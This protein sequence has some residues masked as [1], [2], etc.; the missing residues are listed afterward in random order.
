MNQESR[1]CQNCKA[2]FTIEPEDF[3]FYQKMSVPAPTWCPECRLQRRLAFFNERILYKRNCDLCSKSMMTM[4]APA[5]PMP[6]YCNECWWSDNWDPSSYWLDYDPLRPFFAQW[7]DLVRKTPHVALTVNYPMLINSDYV[8]HTGPAKNCY[9]I[10]TADYC[11]N[12]LYSS[13]LAHAKDSMDC[14]DLGTSELCYESTLCLKCSRVFFSDYCHDCHDIYFSKNLSGCSDCF[15]C[16]NLRNKQYYIFN[17]P[18]SKEAY[19]KSLKSFGLT[20]TRALK[21]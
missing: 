3:A 2:S 8:N 20:R 7:H 21:R 9:L 1:N 4:F 11:E 16:I 14:T 15:G 6:V 19:K 17:E 10:F 12:V 18:Y 13:I 5:A